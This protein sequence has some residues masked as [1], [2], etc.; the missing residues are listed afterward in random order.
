[1]SL[2]NIIKTI[3]K[4]RTFLIST[5]IHPDPDAICSELVL[6]EYLKAIGKHVYL[7]NDE[8]IGE[9]FLFLPG[10]KSIQSV[11]ERKRIRYDVAIIVDCGDF[12]RIGAVRRILKTEE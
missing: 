10:A 2:S 6:G 12:D 5:H 8:K 3:R 7:I 1:M 9:R 11:R 4:Y